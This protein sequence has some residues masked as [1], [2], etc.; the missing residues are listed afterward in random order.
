MLHRLLGD[1]LASTP[2]CAG[3]IK[4]RAVW[5]GNKAIQ[6]W[7]LCWRAEEDKR[8]EIACSSKVKGCMIPGHGS[9][10]A[11]HGEGSYV[12]VMICLM[13]INNPDGQ[14]DYVAV[15]LPWSKCTEAVCG[16]EAKSRGMTFSSDKNTPASL[17]DFLNCWEELNENRMA[18]NQ[19]IEAAL[20]KGK[21]PEIPAGR[22]KIKASKKKSATAAAAAP[23][24]SSIPEAVLARG[25]GSSK[26]RV[27]R[28]LGRGRTRPDV[29]RT[30]T[31]GFQRPMTTKNIDVLLLLSGRPAAG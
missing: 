16:E 29:L 23:K 19:K 1:P 24:P 5:W 8:V 4:P 20:N 17:E 22:I 14:E 28:T 31:F 3:D 13:P 25:E 11:I 10:M 21:G 12:D 27:V 15:S 7:G 6:E 2:V 26:N 30:R 9:V 18:E